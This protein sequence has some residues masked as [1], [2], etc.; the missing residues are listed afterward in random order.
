MDAMMMIQIAMVLFG[1][2]MVWLK[3]P[4]IGNIW[5]VGSLLLAAIT[6]AAHGILEAISR[7]PQG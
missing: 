2:V 3:E 1:L 7:L 4:V 5:W 6:G